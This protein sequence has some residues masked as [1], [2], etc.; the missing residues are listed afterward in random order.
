MSIVI[1]K[2]LNYCSHNVNISYMAK[3]NIIKQAPEKSLITTNLQRCKD[4]FKHTDTF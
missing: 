4:S 2:L 3:H 1:G